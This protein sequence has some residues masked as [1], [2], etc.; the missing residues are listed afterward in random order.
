MIAFKCAEG[1]E[2]NICTADVSFCS[3]ALNIL[4]FS[5]DCL[6]QI[7]AGPS[8]LLYQALAHLQ[9]R[10]LICLI[11]SITELD[12]SK[13]RI[14][15]TGHS[16]SCTVVYYS[17]QAVAFRGSNARKRLYVSVCLC[18]HEGLKDYQCACLFWGHASA[19]QYWT[20]LRTCLQ[21]A[22]CYTT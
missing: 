20:H 6:N 9:W 4:S 21:N 7:T 19:L 2:A 14:Q 13:Y 12:L 8:F 10:G 5:I 3:H 11:I 18:L 15:K 22:S 1:S 16:V 17:G